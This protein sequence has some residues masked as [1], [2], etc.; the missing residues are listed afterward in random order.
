MS[1]NDDSQ[2]AEVDSK[3]RAKKKP[4]PKKKNIENTSNMTK[5]GG[6]D[7][8]PLVT[9]AGCKTAYTFCAGC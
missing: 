2:E 5:A 3:K 8:S 1:T 6:N 9:I 4:L 7:T